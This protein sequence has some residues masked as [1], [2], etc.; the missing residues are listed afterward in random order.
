[1]RI[2]DKHQMKMTD[3][4]ATYSGSQKS[5]ESAKPVA[6]YREFEQ[7]NERDIEEII[8]ENIRE[9]ISDLSRLPPVSHD[10]IHEYL[11]I[12][13]SFGNELKG[14]LKHK[15][16]GCQLFKEGFVEKIRVKNNVMYCQCHVIVI[17]NDNVIQ[18][19]KKNIFS[20]I[21]SVSIN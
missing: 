18:C 21:V 4:H 7:E 1:M 17:V 16:N 11:V 3:H 6:V 8:Q 20:E 14:V 5:C 19:H 12:G 15:I 10:K 2:L 13:K 9:W